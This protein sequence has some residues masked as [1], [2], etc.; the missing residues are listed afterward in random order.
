MPRSTIRRIPVILHR[1]SKTC[2]FM[3]KHALPVT[4]LRPMARCDID[5]VMAIETRV[6]AHPWTKGI[7]ADCLR[8]GYEC[9]IAECDGAIAG[10][11]V[12]SVAAGESH[13]LNLAVDRPFQGRGLGRFLLGHLLQCARRLGAD[14]ALLEVR[15]S[16]RSAIALYEDSGF[17]LIGCRKNYYPGAQDREDAL[18]Y[19]IDLD[20]LHM[21]HD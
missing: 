14:T 8:V 19:A 6:Y 12:L 21:N 9:W 13:V 1:L 15:P 10:Y 17:N 20:T 7:F 5:T 3:P 16:N 18:L 4:D 11:G 2:R